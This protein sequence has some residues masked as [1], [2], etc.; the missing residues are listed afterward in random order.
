[1]LSMAPVLTLRV[2]TKMTVGYKKRCTYATTMIMLLNNIITTAHNGVRTV[3]VPIEKNI[4]LK[5]HTVLSL[6][7]KQDESSVLCHASKA[8]RHIF[9]LHLCNTQV[10]LIGR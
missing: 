8:R 2:Y 1:M 9:E 5:G 3:K 7:S 4:Y 6:H 10:F